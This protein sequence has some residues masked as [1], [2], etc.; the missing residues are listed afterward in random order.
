MELYV[1]SNSTE[2]YANLRELATIV[3][4]L[5]WLVRFGL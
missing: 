4:F 5:L 1:N 2:R 3:L